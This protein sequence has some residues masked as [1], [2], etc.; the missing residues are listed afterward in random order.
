M[1]NTFMLFSAVAVTL[2]GALSANAADQYVNGYYRSNGTY[3]QGYH[4]TAPDNTVNNNYGT[5]GNVNPYTGANGNRPRNEAQPQG[6]YN[7]GNGMGYGNNVYMP[8]SG[9]NNGD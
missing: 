5:Y 8:F 7:R 3:V 4:R 2:F 9:T 1:R 6:E